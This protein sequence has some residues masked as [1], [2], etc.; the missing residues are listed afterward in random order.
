[1]WR[2]LSVAA[3]RVER[4]HRGR[5]PTTTRVYLTSA[6]AL[7]SHP[8]SSAMISLCTSVGASLHAVS[9]TPTCR[10]RRSP[11][12]QPAGFVAWIND[13]RGATSFVGSDGG[14]DPVGSR[15]RP[16]RDLERRNLEIRECDARVRFGA[17]AL[18]ARRRYRSESRV[19]RRRWPR[20]WE[21]FRRGRPWRLGRGGSPRIC[22][23]TSEFE[24]GVWRTA[25]GRIPSARRRFPSWIPVVNDA[26]LSVRPALWTAPT[27]FAATFPHRA[28]LPKPELSDSPGGGAPWRRLDYRS[29]RGACATLLTEE[30]C[31]LV[32]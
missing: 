25:S 2:I 28:M 14:R 26:R 13:R 22:S 20:A 21:V 11:C 24:I 3:G 27:R 31:R 18:D 23:R 29:V 7:V 10:G 30:T 32:P 5:K 16:G 6:T 12:R 17:P 9:A 4:N 15:R 8:R 19:V 1:M